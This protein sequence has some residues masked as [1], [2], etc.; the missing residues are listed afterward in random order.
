[1]HIAVCDDNIA[2]RKQMERLL[3]R[4]SNQQKKNGHEGYYVDLYGNIPSLMQYPQMYDVIFLD[5]VNGSQNGLDIALKLRA[6]GIVCCIV[7]CSSVWDYETLSGSSHDSFLYM[8]K[9]ILAA[10]LSDM[11][12]VCE[13]KRIHSEP[14]V[15]LRGESQTI[16]AHCDEILYATTLQKGLL[17]V[18]LTDHRN[19]HILSDAANF[20]EQLVDFYSFIPITD[21]SI[22]NIHHMISRSLM[23]VIM[24]DGQ[25][26]YV[27]PTFWS[28]VKEA[29]RVTK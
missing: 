11:L 19:V 4:A 17:S 21:H 20:Y 18:T 9:P 6:D 12:I 7:L 23:R 24:D 14:M 27:S 2:D 5:I 13:K 8:H 25:K 29:L 15:E 3:A 26:F 28:N 16:Y 10:E 22:I 1:M